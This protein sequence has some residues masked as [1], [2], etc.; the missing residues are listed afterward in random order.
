MLLERFPSSAYPVPDDIAPQP[1]PAGALNGFSRSVGA[2]R[3]VG[4][5]VF[6]TFK[7]GPNKDWE[8]A[9]ALMVGNG[10]GLNF[11]DNDD[12][13][14][15]YMYVSA[16]KVYGGKGPRREGMKFWAWH[17]DGKRTADLTNDGT[18]NPV[19]Y[20]R[21]RSGLG[22][23]Y[24]KKPYRVTAEYM[25]GDGM[26]FLG[27]HHPSFGLGPGIGIP[28]AAGNGVL[29]E[30]DGWYVEG[31]W[32]IPGTNWEIDARYDVYNRMTDNNFEFEYTRLTLGTQY[33]FNKK[34]RVAVNYEFNEAEA[35]NFGAGAGPNANLDGIDDRIAVQ[36]TA[37][38]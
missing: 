9:Y 38:F 3:D 11:S 34:T 29:S 37:I 1:I 24:L 12:D 10:N 6:D 5:Q 23:K 28:G 18:A 16:E 13:K 8:A 15:V 19:A 31:G 32:Y 33:H 27:P 14:D 4:I 22:F 7:V 30:S 17:Q 36:V 21:D 2:F 35:V 26:I 25:Q 20:D